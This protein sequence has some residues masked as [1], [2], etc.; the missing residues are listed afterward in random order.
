MRREFGRK[1]PRQA[2]LHA[3]FGERFDN[4]VNVGGA[5]SREAR[6][7]IHV[8]FVHHHGA[9]HGAKDALGNLHVAVCGMRA[10]RD[11]R[12]SLADQ[13]GRIRHGAHNAHWT[14]DFLLDERR[15]NGGCGGNN[16]SVRRQHFAHLAEKALH[17]L[18]L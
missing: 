9:A 18:R 4:C 7:G 5:G 15:R 2:E 14:A 13:T 12:H 8:F 3:A 1:L 16:H 17:L 6:D 10:A 11:G